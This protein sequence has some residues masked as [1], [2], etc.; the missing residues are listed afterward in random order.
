MK[1]WL[2]LAEAAERIRKEGTTLASA[3]RRI[4]R[5]VE[6][7][8]LLPLAGHYKADD[9]LRAEKVMRARRGRPRKTVGKGVSTVEEKS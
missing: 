6:A 3:E 9:V 7:G 5:W 2:T 1:A 8:E 4:R